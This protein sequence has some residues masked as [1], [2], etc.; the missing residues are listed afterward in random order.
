MSTND[1]NFRE[2]STGLGMILKKSPD[3]LGLHTEIFVGKIM[4]GLECALK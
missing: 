4:R 2:C 1:F 3:C